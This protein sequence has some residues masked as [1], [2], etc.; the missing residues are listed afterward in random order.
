MHLRYITFYRC[1]LCRKC[2]EKSASDDF[3]CSNSDRCRTPQR[4]ILQPAKLALSETTP[5]V[6]VSKM[7]PL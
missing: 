4:T 7:K 3:S 1:G 5:N 2:G 6:K